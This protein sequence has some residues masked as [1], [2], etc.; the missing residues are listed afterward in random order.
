[1][2]LFN[3]GPASRKRAKAEVNA[4]VAADITQALDDAHAKA[5]EVA[6]NGSDWNINER[7]K[8][9]LD[10]MSANSTAAS[11][12]FTNVITCLA[13]KAA[14]PALDVRVHQVQIGAPFNFRG[15]SEKV[16]YRWLSLHDFNGAKSGWQTRTFE[17]PKPYT[18]DFDENIGKIKGAFLACLDEVQEKGSSALE[19]LSYL[20]LDQI[21][22]LGRKAKILA[23]VQVN[24]DDDIS[25]II[26]F[27][28]QHFSYKY[29]SKGA[30]RLPVLALYAA[31]TLI[32]EQVSRY[33]DKMLLP[34]NRHSAADIRT[35]AM[36]D[37]EIAREDD[38]VFEAIEV[39]HNIQINDML[40]RDAEKKVIGQGLDRYY[41][42]TTHPNCK[43]D[44]PLLALLKGARTRTGCQ[45]I[46]NGVIPSLQYYLRLLLE[47]RLIIPL[48][49]ELLDAE[50]A[51]DNEHRSAWAEIIGLGAD[52]EAATKSAP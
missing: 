48:Y 17:R 27:F 7:F 22:G 9:S 12:G 44:A 10:Q 38:S 49:M 45:I 2:S 30:S 36:G 25:T 33:S 34:L 5:V 40:I 13:I 28:S 32:T 8:A 19:G 21:N 23:D 50:Q 24:E 47:P 20:V 6:G 39:K 51:I 37:I 46:V 14:K 16:V 41:I 4:D 15:Y 11:T 3:S 31:Y 35:G 1:M 42:L 29:H 52:E 26:G 43:P 18:L